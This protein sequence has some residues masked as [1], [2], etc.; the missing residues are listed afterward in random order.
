MKTN[1]ESNG[2]QGGEPGEPVEAEIDIDAN[3][4]DSD[5]QNDRVSSNSKNN[6]C[7]DTKILKAPK[8]PKIKG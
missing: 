1:E 6:N 8:K 3:S 5:N 2:K 7:M 4:E